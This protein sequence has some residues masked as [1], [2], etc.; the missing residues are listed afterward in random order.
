MCGPAAIIGQKRRQS[1]RIEVAAVPD[2][3]NYGKI[4]E[5]G[6]SGAVF[7]AIY[8]NF[9]PSAPKQKMQKLEAFEYLK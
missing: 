2:Q 6:R 4:G 5:T 9:T 3:E 7:I 8:S 1:R